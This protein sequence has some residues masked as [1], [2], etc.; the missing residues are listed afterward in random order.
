LIWAMSLAGKSEIWL[1]MPAVI[2]SL[3]A[4]FVVFRF[5]SRATGRVSV[6]WLAALLVTLAPLSMRY[7]RDLTPYSLVGLL[8]LASTY[9][10]YAALTTGERCHWRRYA[11]TCVA[12]FF[13]HYFTLFLFLGH[14]LALL[15]IWLR[16][17]RGPYWTERFHQALGWIAAMAVLPALWGSQ[18]IRAF[19]ISEQD[20]IVTQAVYNPDVG[21]FPYLAGHLRVMVG[22]P[23]EMSWALWPLVL[24]LVV[25]Y[26][27]LIKDH[28][29]LGHL[30][31]IPVLLLFGLL[32]FVYL[33][34]MEAFGGRIY[35]GWRWL[36]P[37]TM[38][39][40]I[41]A[42]YAMV[43][44]LTPKLRGLVLALGL[45]MLTGVAWAGGR[46]ALTRQR[47]A[48]MAAVNQL[49]SQIRDGD[50]I[51]VLPA[52]F[53]S[54]G[55]GYYLHNKAERYIDSRP[56]G[57]EFVTKK[58]GGRARAFGPLRNFG[59]PLESLA[60]HV[61]MNRL[62]VALF[63]EEIFGQPEF[64]PRVAEHVKAHLDQTLVP[65]KRWRYP[66][67]DLLLYEVPAFQPF[68][69]KSVRLDLRALHR[70]LRWLPDALDPYGL[71]LAMRGEKAL[72]IR[73]PIRTQGPPIS[74]RITG[75][76][77]GAQAAD[78]N[79]KNTTL[80]FNNGIWSGLLSTEKGGFV[81]LTLTRSKAALQ[82]P[83]VLEFN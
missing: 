34:H 33:L 13:L 69:G 68:D 37:Y 47:P 48:Q 60:G 43:R 31:L 3:L 4:A 42:A 65:V 41:P 16:S 49:T 44:P 82:M 67:M 66:R 39:V 56:I 14:F 26:I 20:N 75:A 17:G 29:V 32:V 6:G 81:D 21:F 76:G 38:C 78:L 12:A 15:W 35:F 7:G 5:A 28:P 79:S 74:F 52:A 61:D 18:V 25:G 70:H 58:S 54:P 51:A 8:S 1:R 23:P 27:W 73:I 53:Y 50:V 24:L 10:F 83:L 19:I 62:W 45:V 63:R 46:S 57:W 36:R 22:L 71:Y 59:I 40:A 9:F 2:S 11:I 80:R 64:D 72:R 55:F 77:L 30:L